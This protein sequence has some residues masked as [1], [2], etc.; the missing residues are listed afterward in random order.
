MPDERC[1][2]LAE[3]KAMLEEENAKRELTNDQKLAMEHAQKL[4][5]LS[6]EKARELKEELVQLSFVSEAI[7]CKLVDLLPSHSDDVRVLFAKERLVLDKK[8]IDQI[9]KIVEKYQ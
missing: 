1:I 8:Y 5:K 2:T 3:I 6:A 4:S 9:L 7:A